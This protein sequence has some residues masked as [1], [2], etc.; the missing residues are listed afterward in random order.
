M[1]PLTCLAYSSLSWN[2]VSL[3]FSHAC[4]CS[5]GIVYMDLFSSNII[6]LI[7]SS[8]F[9]RKLRFCRSSISLDSATAAATAFCSCVLSSFK[10][11]FCLS[12]SSL[13]S[14]IFFSSCT[15]ASSQVSCGSPA[16]R[17]NDNLNGSFRSRF[18]RKLS[19]PSSSWTTSL[20]ES[21]VTD[22]L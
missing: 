18:S 6:F 21:S 7:S 10:S 11:L 13:S 20:F 5:N 19:F 14:L 16:L 12:F 15:I 1:C 9:F 4:P 17:P 3:Q 8:R 22:R 2:P